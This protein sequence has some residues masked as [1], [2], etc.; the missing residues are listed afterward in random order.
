MTWN[1][2]DLFKE[3]RYWLDAMINNRCDINYIDGRLNS[4]ID[5]ALNAG[6]IS[7]TT[8]TNLYHLINKAFNIAIGND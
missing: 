4:T 5:M 1:S 2:K 3:L 7:I 6:W 8:W